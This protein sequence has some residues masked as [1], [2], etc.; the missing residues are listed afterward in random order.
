M[1]GGCRF[2]KGNTT[3]NNPLNVAFFPPFRFKDRVIYSLLLTPGRKINT[4]TLLT[5]LINTLTVVSILL[6]H[7]VHRFGS[8]LCSGNEIRSKWIPHLTIVTDLV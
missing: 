7:M 2:S 8:V 4:P 3:I 5:S 6:L 1:V